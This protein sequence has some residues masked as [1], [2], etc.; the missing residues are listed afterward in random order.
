MQTTPSKARPALSLQGA[1][2][3]PDTGD[4]V[5]QKALPTLSTQRVTR[6]A[7]EKAAVQVLRSGKRIAATPAAKAARPDSVPKL[8]DATHSA[9]QEARPA[10][11]PACGILCILSR[12]ASCKLFSPGPLQASKSATQ[13]FV[14][15]PSLCALPNALRP[16]SR[17]LLTGWGARRGAPARSRAGCSAA[18]AAAG[19][20]GACP[21]R[22]AC[23]ARRARARGLLAC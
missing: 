10:Q 7:Y 22:R 19:S 6:Q 15:E 5:R 18:A 3:C 17:P 1:H 20:W 13:V 21:G 23:R 14:V 9:A 8:A 4:A 11:S 2:I 12:A 16:A